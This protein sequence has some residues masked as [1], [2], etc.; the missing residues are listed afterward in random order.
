MS[1]PVGLEEL[2]SNFDRGLQE[3]KHPN[4]KEA[5][6]RVQFIDPFFELLG[7]DMRNTGGQPAHLL[8][9][10]HEDSLE[11]YDDNENK[12]A[13]KAPDYCFRIKGKRIFF[14]EAKK[15]A[16]NL[17]KN[18]Q[19]TYQLKRYAFSAGLPFSILTDFEEFYI[20]DTLIKPNAADS[21]KANRL[22]SYLYT[23]YVDKW[24][25]IYSA[26]SKEAILD[27]AIPKRFTKPTTVDKEF[28]KELDTWRQLLANDLLI[29]NPSVFS[30]NYDALNL[31]V[32]KIIDRILFLRVCEDRGTEPYQDLKRYTDYTQLLTKFQDA[33]ERYN[34]DLFK[35]EDDLTR[36]ITLS[37]DSIKTIIENSY[38]PVCPYEFSVMP[39]QFLGAAY[40]QFLGKVLQDVDGQLQ[41]VEKPEVR[42]AGGVFYTPEY[43]VDIIVSDTLGNLLKG[44]KPEDVDSIKVIDPSCGSGS[45]LIKAY[46]FLLDWHLNYYMTVLSQ[47][48][49]PSRGKYSKI[50]DLNK[51]GT[52]YLVLQEKKR[53]LLNN[54]FGVD[55]DSRAVETT[56]LS[57]MLLMTDGN[58]Q[59]DLFQRKILP[60]LENNIKCGN[61]LMSSDFLS[62]NG[63]S[64]KLNKDFIDKLKLFNW[65]YSFSDVFERGG[66]DA[67][68]GNPPWISLSRR[69][70]N[71]IL[72]DIELAY[73]IDKYQGNEYSPN[74]YEYFVNQG[75]AI[76]KAGGF[77]SYV[78]PDRLNANNQFSTLRKSIK[79]S[80]TIKRLLFDL[81]FPGIT[82]DTMIF[83]FE[84]SKASDD[85]LY[86]VDLYKSK[87]SDSVSQNHYNSDLFYEQ[88]STIIDKCLSGLRL[89]DLFDIKTGV[90][91]DT[92]LMT[93]SQQN[94]NQVAYIK[95]RS[96]AE[97][98]VNNEKY[99]W[100]FFG[101]EFFKGGTCN[102]KLLKINKKV[103]ISKT[104]YPI[105]SAY[106]DAPVICE[107]SLYFIYAN[108]HYSSSFGD[109]EFRFLAPLFQSDLFGYLFWNKLVTNPNST[110]QLKRQDLLCFTIPNNTEALVKLNQLAS[111]IVEYT[112]ADQN[113][114]IIKQH[115]NDLVYELYN[116][117][118]DEK[119]IVRTYLANK[120][121]KK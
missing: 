56:K 85:H 53:I 113:F 13:R 42:K 18:K 71:D 62:Y 99:Y 74:V 100:H 91:V 59:Q 22:G 7:W 73:L 69:F 121:T 87:T 75:I 49:N 21:P 101:K 58:V 109:L 26:Y 88:Q 54:I 29:T 108:K 63:N 117:T 34:S 66:F 8:D 23:D 98:S 52:P 24:D 116:I 67:V 112:K 55:I 72:T 86:S 78:V 47:Q 111:V 14:V 10:I 41:T 83:E 97:F 12:L 45:F 5:R 103:V 105:K 6:V 90:I 25:E 92:K 31:A 19:A 27:G 120:V 17:D 16:I 32:Q 106:V 104:G 4:Y 64:D 48:K 11:D 61:S 110:P 119:K 39:L 50:F 3:Y 38:F 77:I 65:N 84:K 68:I 82:T 28:L 36:Q 96:I 114:N 46:Q 93:T 81:D 44:K 33:N 35:I 15:P 43:M 79:E 118:D 102:E 76:T 89:E 95:G 1:V 94:E 40:E 115:M 107:Q 30:T 20:F 60:N 51:D 37:S 70:K 9:V 80:M 2:V 57:L